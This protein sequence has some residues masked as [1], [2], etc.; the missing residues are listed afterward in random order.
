MEETKRRYVGIDLGKREYTMAIIGRNGKMS[1]HQ[2]KTSDQGR[3]ALYKLLEKGDKAALEAGNLAFIMAREIQ[4]R[5]GCEV[6]V[7][8][9]A[10]L[11][12]SWDAPTKTDKSDFSP[13][14]L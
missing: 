2:G 9:S 3:A 7:L 8:N 13:Q 5:I 10:K 1:L 12:V 11:P 4:E 14:T 6:R